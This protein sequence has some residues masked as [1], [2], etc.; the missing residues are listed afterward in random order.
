[1][2]AHFIEEEGIPTTQISLIRLHTEKIRPPRALWVS[3]ELGRPLGVPN[4]P[5]FQKRVLLAALKLLEAPSG[6][7]LEDYPEDAPITEGESTVL[8]CPV[9]F[10]KE[11]ANLGE[12][13]QLCAA[14]KREFMSMRPWY[15]MAVKKRGR[16]TVGVSGVAVE[17]ISDFICSF[18]QGSVPEN[19]RSDIALPYTLSLV[20]NDLKAY[21]S[22]AITA[23]PGQESTSSQ[24]LLDWFWRETVAGRVLLAIRE[25]SK[26]SPDALMQI[27]GSN[28]IVPTKVAR[29]RK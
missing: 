8:A 10:S 18:L 26:K 25:A 5:A 24:V 21:Y 19:P 17:E 28:L 27:V 20:V 16:T 6:P 15:D 11:E 13:E 3:F 14:F 23:Q 4:D 12:R 29:S 2:L 1:M 22:E 9:S 7:V